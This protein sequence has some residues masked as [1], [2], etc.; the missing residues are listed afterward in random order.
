MVKYP[1]KLSRTFLALADPTRRAIILR[2]TQ[3]ECTVSQLAEPFEISLPAVS[4]HLKILENAGLLS[5]RKEGRTLHC[6][7]E[8][9]PM[10]EAADWLSHY[11][12]F[13]EE[14]FDSLEN[15]LNESEQK[16]ES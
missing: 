4:K 1:S 8:A 9:A 3:G 2:L 12:A 14:R 16:E 6:R 13:W 10:K 11:R 15:F 7:L 5:R